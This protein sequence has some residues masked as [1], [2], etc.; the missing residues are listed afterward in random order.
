MAVNTAEASERSMQDDM[1]P[2]EL[3]KFLPEAVNNSFDYQPSQQPDDQLDDCLGVETAG[4]A[5]IEAAEHVIQPD[6]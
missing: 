1:V 4:A 5:R 3:E 2:I 6:A